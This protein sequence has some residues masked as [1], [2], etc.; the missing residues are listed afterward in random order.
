MR[1]REGLDTLQHVIRQLGDHASEVASSR[2][3]GDDSPLWNLQ[4]KLDGHWDE[5]KQ[6]HFFFTSIRSAY[7][8]D[9]DNI[10]G[11]LESEAGWC[12]VYWVSLEEDE[13]N[14]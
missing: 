8:V 11:L 2:Q 14:G 6:L 7:L 9:H 4:L 1:V 3:G 12:N 10:Y 13:K 5:L